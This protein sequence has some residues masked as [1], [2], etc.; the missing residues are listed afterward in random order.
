MRPS[1]SKYLALLTVAALTSV[2]AAWGSAPGQAAAPDAG[3]A[4]LSSNFSVSDKTAV[5]EA[6]LPAGAYS[7]RVIDHL[8]DRNIVRIVGATDNKVYSTFIGLPDSDL[9]QGSQPGAI[10][11]NA[12][13][14]GQ[15]ALRGFEFP[16]GTA[17]RFVYPKADAVTLAKANS[18]PVVA[19]DP[20]SEGKPSDKNLS[21]DDMEVVTLWTL[22]TTTVGPNDKTPAIQAQ[23]YQA[24][25]NSTVAAAAPSS[26]PA[27]SAPSRA[28]NPAPARSAASSNSAP[29]N[30]A[31]NQVPARP[32]SRPV[33]AKLPHTASNLPLVTLLMFL[34]MLMALGTRW[35]RRG[36]IHASTTR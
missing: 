14:K 17:L 8:R 29:V 26:A 36:L 16:G 28:S 30:V 3:A 27:Y 15:V 6:V 13:F 1:R 4:D 21:K 10:S 2:S 34:S 24:A 35:I 20:V 31:A 18:T 22:S 7:I 32:T 19:I 5:P 33:I 23:R 25:P 11:Y 12:K 9:G